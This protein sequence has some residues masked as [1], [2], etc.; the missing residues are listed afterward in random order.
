MFALQTRYVLRTRYVALRQRE[1]VGAEWHTDLAF[2]QIYLQFM[3]QS[4]NSF[5]RRMKFMMRKH[6]FIKKDN[7]NGGWA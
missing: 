2:M 6:Q 1:K 4:V 3:T 5:I 7:A